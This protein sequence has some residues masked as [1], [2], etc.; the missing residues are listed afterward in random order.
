MQAQKRKANV[1]LVNSIITQQVI[2]QRM[3][4]VIEEI[5]L[6]MENGIP[7]PKRLE[8]EFE[9]LNNELIIQ[10]KIQGEA[11]IVLGINLNLNAVLN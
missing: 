8:M 10:L 1:A 9:K 4:E 11:E 2:K 5:N 7:A 6:K 3:L